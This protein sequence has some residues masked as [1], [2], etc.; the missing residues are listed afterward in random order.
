MKNEKAGIQT[1][2][3]LVRWPTLDH[4]A[5][6]CTYNVE[7]LKNN[8]IDFKLIEFNISLNAPEAK[9]FLLYPD[10]YLTQPS[11]KRPLHKY[12]APEA[13]SFCPLHLH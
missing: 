8:I 12:T 2:N 1:N 9:S 5:S 3:L 4:W 7:K 11:P 13:R 6:T 10:S